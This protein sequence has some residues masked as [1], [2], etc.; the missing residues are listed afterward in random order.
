MEILYLRFFTT[1]L[2][3]GNQDINFGGEYRFEFNEEF[4]KLTGTINPFYVKDFFS[5]HNNSSDLASI[6]NVTS[7]IGENGTGKSSLLRLIKRN[8]ADG[9]GGLEHSLIVALKKEEV[10]TVY[11][12]DGIII[13]THNLIDLNIKLEKLLHED[14]VDR[15]SGKTYKYIVPPKIKDFALTDFISF[16]NIFDG[17]TEM[18]WKGSY[19]IS[20]NFLIRNDLIKNIEY[21]TIN[22]ESNLRQIEIHLFEEIERQIA[23]IN[24]YI[25]KKFLP[26]ELPD[27]IFISSKKEIDYD[28]GFST[29][30]KQILE[31]YGFIDDFL[32]LILLLKEKIDHRGNDTLQDYFIASCILNFI[33]EL[34]STYQNLTEHIKFVLPFSKV[35]KSNSVENIAINLLNDF[36]EQSKKQPYKMDVDHYNWINSARDFIKTLPLLLSKDF[37]LGQTSFS[38]LLKITGSSKE[39]FKK[40]YNSYRDSYRLK[41]FLNFKWR[42]LSSGEKAL[43]NIYARFHSL[44]NS[45]TTNELNKSLII[46]ID[47]GDVYLHPSWQKRFVYLLLDYLPRVYSKTKAGVTRN[48]QIIFTTNSPIPASDLPNDNTIFLEKDGSYSEEKEILG[49]KTLIKDSLN[50]QKET[51]ASNIYT[52]LSDSFF[53]K[54]G[55]I[56][57]FAA[58]KIN[59]IITKLSSGYDIQVSERENIRKI[60][61]QIGEPII[62]HKLFQMYNDRFNLNI[63]ERL[64]KIENHLKF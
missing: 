59:D 5:I 1:E 20:T 4:K 22:H 19:D 51:F 64:D 40:F 29:E 55:L 14:K 23:F 49:P 26:F 52:L 56:G 45:E 35:K 57:D 50:D 25:D 42:S 15:N 53:I 27:H 43:F 3:F 9:S 24:R 36:Q 8:F 6:S 60:I 41:P 11:Y 48:I 18:E 28:F 58:K 38:L 37:T 2:R 17:E 13:K 32:S 39:K 54:D 7:I 10:I 33:L 63:H 30:E 16:S 61:Q 47:E 12:S 44:S 34:A 31:K 46:L 21:K 62:K